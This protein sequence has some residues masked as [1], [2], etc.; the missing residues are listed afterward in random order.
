MKSII[1]ALVLFML[2]PAL[3]VAQTPAPATGKTEF[4]FAGQFLKAHDGYGYVASGALLFPLANGAIVVGPQTSLS[5]SET[6]RS[7]GA[8]LEWNL[9]G[10]QASGPFV[11]IGFDY[12]LTDTPGFQRTST[13]PRA[14][15]KF[16]DKWFLKAY[17]EKVVSGRGK[18][19]SDFGGVVAIGGRF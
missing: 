18:N 11:G 12:F 8:A 7:I 2:V 3:V 10:E 9:V 1:L 14:G 17:G 19:D 4:T 5:R 13:V 16:G 15:F 6:K